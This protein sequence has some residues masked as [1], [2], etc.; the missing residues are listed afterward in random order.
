M[1]RADVYV[2]DLTKAY[3]ARVKHTATYLALRLAVTDRL[4]FH[5]RWQIERSFWQI[6][7]GRVQGHVLRTPHRRYLNAPRAQSVPQLI[8]VLISELTKAV[9][10]VGTLPLSMLCQDVSDAHARI[11]LALFDF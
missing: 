8:P 5:C 2:S 6:P 11:L 3:C 4:I 10:L 9:V 7:D 1:S